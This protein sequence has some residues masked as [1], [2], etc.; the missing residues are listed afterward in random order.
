[1]TTVAGAAPPDREATD[2][3]DAVHRAA[4]RA[5]YDVLA[6]VH[7]GR[8]VVMLGRHHRPAGAAGA[9]LGEFDAGPVVVGGVAGQISGAAAVTSARAE[10]AARSRRLAGRAPSGVGCGPAARA[11]A[12][13]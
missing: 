6:G 7:G 5:G 3:L 11:H 9:V 4:R 10:R 13:R 12:G 2:L 1:M 8:L